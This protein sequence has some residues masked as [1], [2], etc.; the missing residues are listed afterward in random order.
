MKMYDHF[1]FLRGEKIQMIK[2]VRQYYQMELRE[3]KDLVEAITID[4]ALP[5]NI[6]VIIPRG[7]LRP[8]GVL[9]AAKGTIDD[10]YKTMRWVIEIRDQHD[11]YTDDRLSYTGTEASAENEARF[12][13]KQNP[14]C[15]VYLHRAVASFKTADVVKT[16]L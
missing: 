11:E 4:P 16:T 7:L 15:S 1:N 2:L 3:A 6:T 8:D 12:Y 10:P 5:A 14:N 13:A 9:P